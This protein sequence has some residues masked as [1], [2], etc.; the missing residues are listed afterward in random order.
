MASKR[1]LILDD[2]QC[3]SYIK[4]HSWCDLIEDGEDIE[5][6][7][8]TNTGALS[9]KDKSSSHIRAYK[10]ID[11]PTTDGTL[12]LWALEMHKKHR[13]THV[14][15]KEEDLIIRAAHVRTLLNIPT[16]LSAETVPF[17]REKVRMKERASQ[18]HFP[19]PPFARLFAPA[20][21]LGFIEK[22]GYPVVIKPTLGCATSGLHLIKNDEELQTYM[23][24]TLFKSID[25]DQ[26]MDL[27]GEFMVE[28]YMKGGMYHVNG[29]AQNGRIIHAWPFAYLHTCLG[30]SQGGK[31][32]G[33]TYI[34]RSDP[35]HKWLCQAAQRLLDILPTPTDG[36]VFHLELYE[37]LDENRLPDDHFV[38]C[39]IAARAPGG[40]ITHLMDL[41]TYPGDEKQSFARLNFRTSVSLPLPSIPEV[42]EDKVITDLMIPRRPGKLMF[43]PRECP[44][45]NLEYI[46]IADV[47]TP[48]TY[49]KYDVNGLNVTC[50]FIARTDTIDEGQALVNQGFDWFEENH[51]NKPPDE[52][53]TVSLIKELH[54]YFHRK[55]FI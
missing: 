14:Y 50:R 31:A 10:E 55:I 42:N 15:T 43:L 22:H 25:I 19:V 1:V 26:R 12:E 54:R 39:E 20:D 11:H 2:C 35:R 40:S 23:S 36:L 17:Y 53:C 52:P 41:V 49:E 3:P 37:N 4:G 21:L 13:F 28:G 46:P 34:P 5:L 38:L 45:Q 32:Y 8:L 9:E 51:I 16:G 6:Y 33:N 24:S 18:G 44:I 47:D 7:I 30:F 27:V 48:S 29:I